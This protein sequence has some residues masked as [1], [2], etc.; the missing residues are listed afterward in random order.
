V[1]VAAG[2]TARWIVGDTS[3]GSG[4]TLRINVMVYRRLF[5]Q[6]HRYTGQ[7]RQHNGLIHL[8][9]SPKPAC[10]GLVA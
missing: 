8:P 7:Y 6:H 9:V 5:Q 2:D 10:C 3:S 1:T 4:D